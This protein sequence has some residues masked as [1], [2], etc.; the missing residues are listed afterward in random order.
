MIYT[1]TII[2]MV[3]GFILGFMTACALKNK[4]HLINLDDS[5]KVEL[6]KCC[7]DEKCYSKPPHLRTNCKEK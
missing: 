6:S 7:E 3:I 5:R 1:N 2:L 4:E